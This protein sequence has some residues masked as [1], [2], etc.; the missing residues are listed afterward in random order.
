MESSEPLMVSLQPE[1][2]TGLVDSAIPAPAK[3]QGGLFYWE[4]GIARFAFL[5]NQNKCFFISV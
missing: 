2:Y 4:S 1:E 5:Q 3:F